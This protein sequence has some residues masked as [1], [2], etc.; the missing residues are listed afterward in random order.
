MPWPEQNYAY[1]IRNFGSSSTDTQPAGTGYVFV[2]PR[3]KYTF[4]AYLEVNPDAEPEWYQDAVKNGRFL[5]SLVS[6]GHPSVE[7]ETETMRTYNG[8]RVVPMKMK[9]KPIT[10]KLRDDSPSFVMNLLK[11]YRAHYHNSGDA[12]SKDDFGDTLPGIGQRGGELD[13][14]GLKAKSIRHFF[15]RMV[16]YD[17]GTAPGSVNVYYLINPMITTI[18]HDPLDY[19]DST[20]FVDL[21][22]SVEYEGF[23]EEIGKPVTDYPDALKQLGDQT[24]T[25]NTQLGGSTSTDFFGGMVDRLVGGLP[26]ILAGAA[27][28]GGINFSSLKQGLIQNVLG[29][30][31]LP[32][33]QAAVRAAQ[34]ISGKTRNG[35]YSSVVGLASSVL[36]GVLTGTIAFD[37]D[38]SARPTYPTTT[39]P[40]S[41]ALRSATDLMKTVRIGG[42]SWI[43][44]VGD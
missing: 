6:I 12:K 39:D 34:S 11:A 10:L 5:A 21:S 20:G 42:T 24:A 31:P 14:L 16:I 4:F 2:Q 27:G 37:S 9:Y 3:P 17:L 41:L 23:Y 43:D 29:N 25:S 18:D 26:G 33:I 28:S 15:S 7:F 13:S 19:Y 35:D 30:G 44:L 32:Q 22:M 40:S 36:R 38:G 8:Y 1:D